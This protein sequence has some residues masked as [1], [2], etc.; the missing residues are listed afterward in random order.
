MEKKIFNLYI[1]LDIYDILSNILYFFFLKLK[2]N[3]FEILENIIL[4]I[5]R[6]YVYYFL[7][8]Y[9]FGL[10]DIY[11]QLFCINYLILNIFYYKLYI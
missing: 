10:F 3:N 7:C 4:E 2:N 6:N 8:L 11:L 5:Y 9:Y 1:D